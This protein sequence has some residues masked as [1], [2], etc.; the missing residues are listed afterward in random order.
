MQI[1]PN[2]SY[3]GSSGQTLTKNVSTTLCGWQIC[4]QTHVLCGCTTFGTELKL[5]TTLTRS[6][7]RCS[8]D[9]SVAYTRG[10]GGG[11]T[12][13]H[14]RDWCGCK[15]RLHTDALTKAW[16]TPLPHI[17]QKLHN[18]EHNDLVGIGSRQ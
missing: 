4:H 9:K 1:S 18:G 2:Q 7:R 16:C 17:I 13:K 11:V 10:G 6:I 14:K 3:G 12:E 5:G 15:E 8:L